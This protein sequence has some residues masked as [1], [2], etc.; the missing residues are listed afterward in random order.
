M[1]NFDAR[2]IEFINSVGADVKNI[3]ATEGL[4]ANLTTTE[5]TSLV[6]AINEVN[7]KSGGLS[8][9]QVDA[10]ITTAVNA[11]IAGAPTALD[12]LKEIADQLAADE[13]VS[14]ALTTAVNN[15]V[16]FDSVQ[17]LTTEQKLQACQNI[18]IGNPDT[19]F[20]ATYNAAKV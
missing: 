9:S 16:R 19:D 17:T 13:S 2:I 3:K 20:V 15:R 4:L 8:E 1:A 14:A 11:L 7:A 5:K 12:T 18:G 10:K 6:L